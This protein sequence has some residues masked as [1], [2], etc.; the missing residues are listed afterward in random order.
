VVKIERVCFPRAKEQPRL[1]GHPE[2][3]QKRENIE[4]VVCVVAEGVSR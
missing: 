3:R 1:R 2:I 4:E